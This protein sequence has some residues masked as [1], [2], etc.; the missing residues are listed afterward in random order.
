MNQQE[1]KIYDYVTT[2][3]YLGLP[4]DTGNSNTQV[5]VSMLRWFEQLRQLG[6]PTIHT[7]EFEKMPAMPPNR[8]KFTNPSNANTY[9]QAYLSLGITQEH[10]VGDTDTPL[11]S[12]TK[13]RLQYLPQVDTSLPNPKQRGE[14]ALKAYTSLS[15]ALKSRMLPLNSNVCSY[16]TVLSFTKALL[17]EIR[18]VDLKNYKSTLV[19]EV[20]RNIEY[21]NKLVGEPRY[22]KFFISTSA[23]SDYYDA[24]KDIVGEWIDAQQG[25]SIE[26]VNQSMCAV[27]NEFFHDFN[28]FVPERFQIADVGDYY[29]SYLASVLAGRY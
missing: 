17:M 11:L 4:Y 3:Q 23:Y 28:S 18:G 15:D 29:T 16:F 6:R 22:N 5:N 14:R 24:F 1:T 27:W 2:I 10:L 25:S 20:N 21:C 13:D 26:E 9:Y 7:A 8:Y 12:L 19:F